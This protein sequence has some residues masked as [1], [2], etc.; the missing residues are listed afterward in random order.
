MW[1]TGTLIT[2]EATIKF[3]LDELK[4]SPSYYNTRILEAIDQR[5][6]Q[7]RYTEAS[8]II[9]Y[10]HNPRAQLE[11]KAVVNKFC[12]QLLSRM[13]E[14]EEETL[15]DEIELTDATEN[16]SEV[17]QSEELS[18]A[19]KLQIAIDASLKKPHEITPCKSSLSTNLKYEL[20]VAEQTGKRG[21]LLENI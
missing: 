15:D 12:C 19:N 20:A 14:N 1:Y 13:G 16:S 3:L 10:L 17:I 6:I 21:S 5:I 8:V 2:A 11:K 18:I 7:E 9:Q 4:K